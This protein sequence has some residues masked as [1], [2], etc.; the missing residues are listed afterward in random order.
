MLLMWAAR[1][2]TP[3]KIEKRMRDIY[4]F[5]P[6][7]CRMTFVFDRLE[8]AAIRIRSVLLV[9]FAFCL[10]AVG[11]KTEAAGKLQS[12]DLSNSIHILYADIQV[13]RRTEDQ[14]RNLTQRPFVSAGFKEDP[15][16]RISLGQD[17][18]GTQTFENKNGYYPRPF[19]QSMVEDSENMVFRFEEVELMSTIEEILISYESVSITG[20]ESFWY[21]RLQG[22][23]EE[24]PYA[25]GR[26]LR[27]LGG[28]QELPQ[29]ADM[30]KF[31][32]DH[33]N[34]QVA[35]S[36]DMRRMWRSRRVLGE[37]VPDRFRLECSREYKEWLKKS[38]AG[39]I[40]PGLNVSHIIADVGAKHQVRLHRLQEK[41]DKSELEHQRR[42]SEDAKVIARFKQE[43]RRARQCMT[44]LDDNM[45]RQIQSVEGFRHQ[46]GARLGRNH[47]W[48]NKYAMWEE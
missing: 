12:A 8:C 14:I 33:E 47:L 13:E 46:E 7:V 42:H 44:E 38:L 19:P 28:K 10:L 31:V 22:L 6:F 35:F 18:S 25:P 9:A 4:K 37:P 15:I 17:E 26:V 21:P 24:A 16:I 34:G 5:G 2:Q 40:E 41:F 1:L 39:T 32:T 11:R 3:M 45:E 20:G 27:K 48:A 30:R 23:R 29:I 36:E 43:L